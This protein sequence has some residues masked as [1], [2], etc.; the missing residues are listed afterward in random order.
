[1]S[2]PRCDS[3]GAAAGGWLWRAGQDAGPYLLLM[4]SVF[5]WLCERTKKMQQMDVECL[6]RKCRVTLSRSRCVLCFYRLS[7]VVSNRR[8][9]RERDRACRTAVLRSRIGGGRKVQRQVGCPPPSGGLKTPA[10]RSVRVE[11]WGSQLTGNQLISSFT[12]NNSVAWPICLPLA[13]ASVHVASLI[14]SDRP[15]PLQ[16]SRWSRTAS[17]EGDRRQVA[18]ASR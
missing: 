15:P 2:A 4:R 18:G 9:K 3:A 12:L 1:M 17:A 11:T 16:G 7:A 5:S 10:L 13:S 6:E 8:Q 14:S